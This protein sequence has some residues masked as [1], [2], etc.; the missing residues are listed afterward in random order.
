MVDDN[1]AIFGVR[2]AVIDRVR[3]RIRAMSTQSTLR[4][5]QYRQLVRDEWTNEATLAAWRKWHPKIVFQLQAMTDSLLEVARVRPDMKALD[6]AS[7]SGVP[8]IDLARAIGP[9]GTVTATDLSEGMLAI[10][11]ANA[12]EAGITNISFQ[13]A[14]V[15]RLPF[16]D[17][18]FDLVTSRL[19]A[20]YFVDFQRAL[21]EIRRLLKP[22]GRVALAVWGPVD[23]GTYVVTTVGPFFKRS[24]VPPAPPRDAPSPYRFADPGTLKDELVGAGFQLVEEHSQTVPVPWSGPP[25]ECW[26]ELYDVAIPLRPIFDGLHAPERVRAIEEAAD[27]LREHYDGTTIHIT[28]SIVVDRGHCLSRNA[29]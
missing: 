26:Q 6:L 19:G 28:A 29:R 17:E 2:N 4:S 16:A 3:D 13:Q 1:A 22:R 21:S 8:A 18:T 9:S 27:L 23:Q 5:D 25:E 20:M 10:A 15:E 24:G 7:G 12:K 14:D 11:E